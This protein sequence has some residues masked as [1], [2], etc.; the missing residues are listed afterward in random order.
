MAVVE[1]GANHLHEIESYCKIALPTHALITNCG[2]AHLEGFGSE[3]GVRKGKGELYDFI[4]A[5]KGIIF[6]NADLAYLKEM[7]KDIAQQITYGHANAQ[8]IGKIISEDV[9]LKI[10]VLT[11]GMETSISTQLAGDFNFP[12]VMAAIAV[13]AHF[14]IGI[15]AIKKAIEQYSPDNSRSQFMEIGSNKIILDAYNA[16]PTSMRA[17][18]QNFA[19]TDLKNKTLWLG[20]MKEMGAEEKNE[21]QALLAFIRK[22]AWKEVICV[23]KEFEGM[24]E[25]MLWFEHSAQAAE[26]IKTHPPINASILIKGSRGSK[27]E[28]L[29][30]AVKSS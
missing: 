11:S 20:A 19:A 24:T 25:G 21:H 26:W 28:A 12:N 4:R 3:E 29:L 5:Q 7:A 15:D 6:R 16:N 8:Y 9:F 1:M 10:A 13:G 2:K 18:I 17:A 14:G 30:E 22:Y 27:M 23:G